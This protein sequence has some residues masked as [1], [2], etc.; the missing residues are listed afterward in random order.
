MGVQLWYLGLL[1]VS[2]LTNLKGLDRIQNQQWSGPV[3]CSDLALMVR[4][5][6]QVCRCQSNEQ[7]ISLF[8]GILTIAYCDLHQWSEWTTHR[9]AAASSLSL[10]LSLSPRPHR[11]DH[12]WRV[13]LSWATHRDT[14]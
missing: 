1:T 5:Q 13:A 6:Q 7:A 3:S 11:C 12:S 14:L 2:R 9:G 8:T 4:L 10:S